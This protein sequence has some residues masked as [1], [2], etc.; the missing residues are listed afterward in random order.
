LKTGGDTITVRC[1][2]GARAAI[3]HGVL[4]RAG[5]GHA[6]EL[7]LDVDEARAT[8]VRQGDTAVVLEA[9]SSTAQ[10]RVLVTERDVLALSARGERVPAGALLTPGARDRARALGLLES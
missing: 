10:R 7:H 3:L 1:G 2:S 6:T 8:G 4:V 9:T 5:S